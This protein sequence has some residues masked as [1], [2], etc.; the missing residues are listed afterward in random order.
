MITIKEASEIIKKTVKPSGCSKT[1]FSLSYGR[2]LAEDIISDMD[3][4]PFNKSAVDGY[5]CRHDDISNPLKVVELIPAGIY[6]KKTVVPGTCSKIMTGAKVPDGADCVVMVEYTSEENGVMKFIGKET[7]P[8]IA[9]QGEDARK[10]QVL[11]KKGTL[12]EPRHIA[13]MASAGCTS[14]LVYDLPSIMIYATGSE[15]VEPGV[16]PG[17]GQIRNSNGY[18]TLSQCLKAG[19]DADFGGIIPDDKQMTFRIIK[20]A[21][22]KNDVVI[23]SG[24]VS[25]GDLD[26]IP[27]VMKELGFEILFNSLAVQPGKP[28]TLAV[29]GNK[30]ILGLPGNPVSSLFQFNLIGKKL[31]YGLCGHNYEWTSYHLKMSGTYKRHR[32]ERTGFVPV[33]LNATCEIELIRYNGSANIQALSDASGFLQID[34]GV[35]EIMKGEYAS[36]RPL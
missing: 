7:G 30:Y 28:T 20:E 35:Y 17:P 23:L 26:F 24:G 14:P 25:K 15:L 16:K 31:L 29:K 5:A 8:N 1:D 21:T 19:F 18:Q 6:P 27:E 4:P 2:I 3:M 10:G 12:I 22:E 13:L 11:V 32:A 34:A 33:K 36:Y 9:I